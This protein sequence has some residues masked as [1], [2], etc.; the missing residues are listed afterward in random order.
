MPLPHLT[1]DGV[2]PAGDYP[3]T[4]SD[5]RASYFVTGGGMSPTWDAGWRRDLVDNLEI[6]ANQ[7]WRVGIERIF[8]NGSF[9]EDSDH[10]RD[11]DGY[12]ECD[13]PYLTS[14]DLQRDLNALDPYGAWDWSHA[15]RRW[16]AAS[17]KF[18]LPMWFR[19]RVELYPHVGQPTGVLDR[20]GNALQ[21]PALFRRTRSGQPKGILRLVR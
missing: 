13:E 12:F 8:I 7:I 17:A 15:S 10:P 16:D 19:Y 1:A 4:L 5:L 3:M 9:I 14:G 21:F 18:Q 11:I 20:F 6:L 2:L